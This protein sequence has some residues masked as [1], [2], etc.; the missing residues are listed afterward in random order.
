[1]AEKYSLKDDLFNAETVGYLAGLFQAA[2]PSFQAQAF[3][4]QVLAPFPELELKQRIDH[5]AAVLAAHLPADFSAAARAIQAALPEPLD[6]TLKDDDFGRF[7]FAPLGEYAVNHGLED[8]PDLSLDLLEAVTQRF[9]MEFAIRPFLN[10]W[11]DRVLARM[12]IW[13]QHDHYHVR[14]LVSEGTRPKL[15]WGMKVGVTSE[16]TLPFLD[17]LHADPTRFVTRSVANHLN[18]IS[19]TDPDLVV[20]TLADWQAEGRQDA[21]ELDWMT[22]HALRGLVKKGHAGALELLGYRSNPDIS[23]TSLQA[24]RDSLEIGE[25]FTFDTVLEAGQDEALM[26]DY[27]ID[28]VKANGSTA[29]KVFKLKQV[30]MKAGSRL[31]LR[32]KHLFKKGAT[33]FTHYPGQHRLSLQ[34]NGKILAG[35]YFTLL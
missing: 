2:D 1:M 20:S 34:V 31:T 30:Q 11:P 3:A 21:K 27:V 26:V 16:Q 6:P 33:T 12:Q 22:R 13:A 14:R 19:K 9:S 15:P 25:S 35:F 24:G 8:H 29:P 5:I 28:F 7:I 32:K 4:D 17:L 10:R 18:D 23:V